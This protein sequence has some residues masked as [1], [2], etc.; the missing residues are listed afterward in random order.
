MTTETH[1]MKFVVD[2]TSVQKGFK[3]YKSAVDG[4]FGSLD[5]FEAH[6]AKTMKGVAS[7]AN[8]KAAL[9]SFKNAVNSFGNT[10]IDPKLARGLTGL[11]AAMKDF[12]AP[13][14]AQSSN[15]KKFFGTLSAM[16][17]LTAAYRT[18]KAIDDLNIAMRGFKSPPVAQ[19]KNLLNFAKTFQQAIPMFKNVGNLSGLAAGGAQISALAGALSNL[20]VPSRGAINNLGNMALA[21][22]SFNFSNLAGSGNMFAT[23]GAIGSFKAPSAGQ[24]KNLQ[25]FLHAVGTMTVPTNGAAVAR[26]LQQIAAASAAAQ[27]SI[28][29]FGGSIGGVNR[30]LGGLSH[31]AAGAKLQMMGLQN[32]FSGTFQI[33]SAL[34]TLLGSLTI[35]ELGREF[36][37]ANN[38][39]L[40][41]NAQMGVVSKATSFAGLQMDYVRATANKFGIDVSSAGDGFAK[42]SIAADKSGLSVLQ[43]RNIFEGFSTAMTVLGTAVAGQGDVWL[44]LQQVMNKGYLSAEELNQQMNEKLPG[45]MAYAGEMA[46]KLGMNLQDAL[47]K[48]ALKAGEVLGYIAKRYKEDFGPSLAA[49]LMKPSSQ[50]TILKNNITGLYQQIGENGVNDAIAKL[51]TNFNKF[52]DPAGVQNF[53]KAIAEGLVSAIDRASAAIDWLRQNWDDLKGPLSTALTLMGQWMLLT[54][55]MQIGK[56]LIGPIIGI[57]AAMTTL[58]GAFTTNGAQAGVVAKT[59]GNLKGQMMPLN[60]GL[61]GLGRV[62]V[63]LAGNFTLLNSN[64]KIV[65][66]GLVGMNAAANV[67]RVGMGGLK[68]AGTG[69]MN[70]FGGPWGV[71]IIAATALL[72]SLYQEHGRTIGII[73]DFNKTAQEQIGFVNTLTGKMQ[74]NAGGAKT[75]GD[76]HK[77][78]A[79]DLQ[80]FINK[81]GEAADE[82]YRMAA[83]QRAANLATLVGNRQKMEVQASELYGQTDAGMR[84]RNGIG[85]SANGLDFIKRSYRSIVA[86]GNNLLTGGEDAKS[87]ERARASMLRGIAA[88][89]R[90][91]EDYKKRALIDEV[92]PGM[93]RVV[94]P[95]TPRA[96]DPEKEKKKKKGRS[97][98]SQ[99]ASL[100]ND[101]DGTMSKLLD[102]DP[103]TKLYQDYVETLTKEGRTLLNDKS[104]KA[105][106]AGLSADM[107]TGKISVQSLIDAIQGGAVKPKVLT[108]L[109]NRYNT[110]TKGLIAMLRTQQAEY[111]NGI[112]EATIKS[113][114]A[115]YKSIDSV[116]ARLGEDD[117]VIKV[118]LDFTSDFTKIASE[119]LTPDALIK[120]TPTLGGL[121]DGSI[122]AADA[123]STL[124]NTLNDQNSVIAAAKPYVDDIITGLARTGDAYDVAKVKAERSKDVIGSFMKE[125]RDAL[126]LSKMTSSQQEIAN[127]LID[128]NNAALAKKQVLTQG[129]I[130]A[131]RERLEL[132]QKE[133]DMLSRQKAQFENNGMR[134]YNKDTMTTAQLVN[135]LDRDALQGLED[136]LYNL[137]MTGKVSFKNLLNSMQGDIMKWAS[138]GTTEMLTGLLK[139]GYKKK[140]A[141]GENPSIFGALAKRI[142]LGNHKTLDPSEVQ[143]DG[144]FGKKDPWTIDPYTDAVANPLKKTA[145]IV[146]E[147]PALKLANGFEAAITNVNPTIATGFQSAMTGTNTVIA[148]DLQTKVAAAVS[149]ATGTPNTGTGLAGLAGAVAPTTLPTGAGG[150][151]SG[152]AGVT[153][154]LPDLSKLTGNTAIKALSEGMPKVAEDFAAKMGDASQNT[155]S[156]FGS[157]MQSIFGSGGAG[158]GIAG[159]LGSLAGAI[160]GGGGGG[161]GGMMKFL[162]PLL[163]AG[164]FSEGGFP[165]SPVSTTAI[166]P[167]V[168]SNAPHYKEGT[169]NTSGIPAILHDNE[170]VIPLSR[171]RKVPVQMTG[172]GG[173]GNGTVVN[174]NYQVTSPNA[175]SFKKSRQ[176]I[177]TD[178][179]MQANRAF[180]RNN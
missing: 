37:E 123:V 150:A 9:N 117:P 171:G 81:V 35:G 14:A 159:I 103:M 68:A 140:I 167:A 173:G 80:P 67:A 110:D 102:G 58:T 7:A 75:L 59:W 16:P 99:L 36:F 85:G 71:A 88:S 143:R 82:L 13:T 113:I 22:R 180:R 100:Q 92:D 139:P 179:H 105:W 164:L 43:T 94:A 38:N 20:K 61:A 69:V 170:A 129:E 60:S 127:K 165:G 115:T 98:A 168:F 55:S 133:A 76:Q 21:L 6:V 155:A 166:N 46:R 79:A 119:M 126:N 72:Y 160:G 48:K 118:K 90:I 121:R 4:I 77:I 116:M 54:G 52:L 109:K 18:I 178:M 157:M 39:L 95:G 70:L 25:N 65:S 142:G 78:A 3:D 27:G 34:R 125:Q 51:L 84:E 172:G 53:A 138:K 23:L 26:I 17:N 63:G 64:S 41:F 87:A 162:S 108:D 1:G 56:A 177:A 151:M 136:T 96:K 176:Q 175:D 28:G 152:L 5:K 73:E 66:G 149:A 174:M 146:E 86:G 135:N 24:I 40:K 141:A 44:A 30:A 89:K 11:S 147:D 62:G 10:N 131:A 93:L 161:A 114:D 104:F 83:A 57:G 132:M 153:A 145:V 130:K 112:K 32:A 12:K 156:G 47:S 134:A 169:G 163:S 45:A 29:R 101:L 8:N 122:S 42:I 97:A 124:T 158:G 19:A 148:N 128:L 49:A 33:G 120:M 111:E 106:S 91:E 144:E 137:G 107:K 31:G 2:T 74:E 154:Y 15:L 50:M